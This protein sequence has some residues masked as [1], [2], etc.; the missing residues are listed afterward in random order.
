MKTLHTF[1]LIIFCS[2]LII[3]TAS[4]AD[5]RHS[6]HSNNTKHYSGFSRQ[7]D[8]RHDR[9]PQ[10]YSHNQRWHAK[11]HLNKQHYKQQQY[12]R[13]DYRYSS[14]NYHPKHYGYNKHQP[15]HYNYTN[16]RARYSNDYYRAQRLNNTLNRLNYYNP[17]LNLYLRF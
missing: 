4:L 9:H 17:G 10:A 8:N 7:Q 14:N 12:D 11:K 6:D 16:N 5:R 15:K 1:S 2:L 13:Y 3:S